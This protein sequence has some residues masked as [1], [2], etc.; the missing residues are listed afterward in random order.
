MSTDG[1]RDGGDHDAGDRE[2]GYVETYSG[3]RFY[4]FDP[5]PADVRIEDLAHGLAHTCRYSGQ[6]Q[7]YYSVAEH[8]LHVARE[9]RREGHGPRVQCYGLFHDAA[10]AYLPDLP[11]PIKAEF[12]AFVDLERSILEAVW[13]A[14]DLRAPTTDEWDAVMAADD[15][16]L[17]YEAGELLADGGWADPVDLAHDLRA[18]SPAAARE[19]FVD[20]AGTLLERA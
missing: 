1:D 5:R 2:G 18:D 3:G 11:R 19:R 7:V 6:C 13:P 12:D 10:E 9:L 15:R 8:S 4:P 16:L 20:R 14:L 17:H